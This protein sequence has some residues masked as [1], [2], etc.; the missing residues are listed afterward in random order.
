VPRETSDELAERLGAQW[1]D[2]AFEYALPHAKFVLEVAA[3]LE[4][5]ANELG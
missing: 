3:R 1:V 4:V 2:P 5:I